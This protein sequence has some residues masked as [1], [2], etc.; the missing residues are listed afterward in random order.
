MEERTN[1]VHEKPDDDEY[2][3][4]VHVVGNEGTPESANDDESD[5]TDGKQHGRS[6]DIHAC[7]SG[8]GSAAAEEKNGRDQ[9]RRDDRVE[10]EIILSVWFVSNGQTRFTVN[11]ICAG[12]PKR[13]LTISKNVLAPLAFRFTADA[14]TEKKTMETLEHLCQQ[15]TRGELEKKNSRSA[16]TVPPA[17]SDTELV[18][19]ESR[20]HESG[21]PSPSRDLLKA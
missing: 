8:D 17:T 10:L 4:R 9:Q 1:R 16:H 20:D 12:V 11:M 6:P 5:D 13:A 15:Y 2:N 14:M 3:G 18:S 19:D 21:A 7:Q